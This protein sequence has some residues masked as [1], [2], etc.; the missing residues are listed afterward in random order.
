MSRYPP[1]VIEAR[2]SL[3]VVFRSRGRKW[4]DADWHYSLI[5]VRDV[6]FERSMHAACPTVNC[7]LS[8]RML[9]SLR[10]RCPFLMHGTRERVACSTEIW[11]AEPKCRVDLTELRMSVQGGLRISR[12]RTKNHDGVT[13]EKNTPLEA[14]NG[15][16]EDLQR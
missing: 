11:L 7:Q 14:H 3:R 4:Q 5:L 9:R 16:H 15:V 6:P 13:S 2:S 8:T 1:F 10:V 12:V